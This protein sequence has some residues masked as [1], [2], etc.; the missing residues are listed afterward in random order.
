MATTSRQRAC[1]V[2]VEDDELDI[3][4]VRRAISPLEWVDLAVASDG[5]QALAL[6]RGEN[7]SRVRRPY[8]ILVDINMPRMDGHEFLDELRSDPLLSDSVVFVL[9]T[10]TSD[11]DRRAAFDRH[12]AGFL[13]KQRTGPNGRRLRNLFESYLELSDLPP[14]HEA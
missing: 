4:W 14:E 1:I 11:R 5:E 12:V 10:S 6:L 7:C 13:D 3:E 9:T 2:L 8:L